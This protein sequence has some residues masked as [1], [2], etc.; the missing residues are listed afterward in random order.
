M[1][2]INISEVWP[3]IFGKY[4]NIIAAQIHLQ[5]VSIKPSSQIKVTFSFQFQNYLFSTKLS[6]AEFYEINRLLILSWTQNIFFFTYFLQLRFEF[7]SMR[8]SYRRKMWTTGIDCAKFAFGIRL[9]QGPEIEKGWWLHCDSLPLTGPFRYLV[10]I[11]HHQQRYRNHYLSPPSES[12]SPT[13]TWFEL[14]E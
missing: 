7:Q 1:L 10:I 3:C 4:T 8:M 11:S 2:A 13:S 5:C 14:P 12:S 9:L 6:I